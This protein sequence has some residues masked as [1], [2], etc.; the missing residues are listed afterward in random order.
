[1]KR[2]FALIGIRGNIDNL[3]VFCLVI[4]SWIQHILNLVF[5]PHVIN[6]SYPH[7]GTSEMMNDLLTVRRSRSVPSSPTVHWTS[8]PSFGNMGHSASFGDFGSFATNFGRGG[9]YVEDVGA[10]EMT[11]TGW[12]FILIKCCLCIFYYS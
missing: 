6:Y 1:M 10:P 12:K 8:T 3:F 5:V 11:P 9:S 7:V 2:D 4:I